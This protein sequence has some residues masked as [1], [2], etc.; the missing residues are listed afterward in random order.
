MLFYVKTCLVPRSNPNIRYIQR[1]TDSVPVCSRVVSPARKSGAHSG[2][3]LFYCCFVSQPEQTYGYTRIC[4]EMGTHM[5]TNVT[6]VLEPLEHVCQ[7]SKLC[8]TVRYKCI[9][10]WKK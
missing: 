8:L 1:S 9:E 7:H 10:I 2:A 5:E 3:S 4:Y 6:N